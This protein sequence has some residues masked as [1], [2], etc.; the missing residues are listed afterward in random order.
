MNSLLFGVGVGI[1]IGLV[2][3]ILVAKLYRQ[4]RRAP[5]EGAPVDGK[6]VLD[7]IEG[8]RQQNSAE[9]MGFQHEQQGQARSLAKLL[10]R[11]GFL[12]RIK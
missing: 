4:Q 2:T 6:G 1:G 5:V 8:M 10:D 3:L 11:F 9:H 12:K 7:A